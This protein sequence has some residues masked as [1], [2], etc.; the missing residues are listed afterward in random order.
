M[1][2]IKNMILNRVYVLGGGI[3]KIIP[4]LK[5]GKLCKKNL[6]PQHDPLIKNGM[7]QP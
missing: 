7:Q 4:L 6:W 2:S 5:R 3:I 1:S